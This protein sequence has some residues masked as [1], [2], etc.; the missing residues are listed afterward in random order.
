MIGYLLL[1]MLRVVWD[2]IISLLVSRPNQDKEEHWIHDI[3]EFA[4]SQGFELEEH[5][6]HTPD[7]FVLVMFRIKTEKRGPPVLFMHGLC[8]SCECFITDRDSLAFSMATKGYDVWLGNARGNRYSYK[9]TKLTPKQEEYWDF[10]MD[11]MALV[12]LPLM[13]LHVLE[14]SKYLKLDY[15][16][17]SQGTAIGFACFS[18]RKDIADKVSNFLAI[19]PAGRLNRLPN[20]VIRAIV[21]TDPKLVFKIFGKKS[22][23]PSVFFWRRVLSKQAF[24]D[25]MEKSVNHIFGWTMTNVA[26]HQ[27]YFLYSNLYSFTSTKVIV[28]WMQIMS[29]GVLEMFDDDVHHLKANRGRRTPIYPLDRIPCKI[30]LLYGNKDLNLINIA[31]LIESLPQVPNQVS[32]H[33]FNSLEHLDLI[34]CS[35]EH[36]V[37]DVSLSCL[38]SLSDSVLIPRIALQRRVSRDNTSKLEKPA[39]KRERAKSSCM[40]NLK[41]ANFNQ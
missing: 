8:Q 22:V 10:S 12:D 36:G 30:H 14:H 21:S 29:S 33:C 4:K 25:A 24:L 23:L 20:P 16:G 5:H 18:V 6:V 35:K 41:N 3:L 38:V 26:S 2:Q 11:E 31:N 9:N 28:H 1:M 39:F 37:N 27:K 17:F 7:G 34:Y 19:S 13:I 32:V 40:Q 15:V